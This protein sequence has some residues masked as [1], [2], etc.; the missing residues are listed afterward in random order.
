MG[1]WG[2]STRRQEQHEPEGRGSGCRSPRRLVSIDPHLEGVTPYSPMGRRAPV[3]EVVPALAGLAAALVLMPS[4]WPVMTA[5]FVGCSAV[6][7][8]FQYVS[9]RQRL[10]RQLTAA[11]PPPPDVVEV[12]RTRRRRT[13]VTRI[14]LAPAFLLGAAWLTSAAEHNPFA[15]GLVAAATLVGTG[16]A[17]DLVEFSTIRRWERRNGRV[18]KSL[19]LEGVFYVERGM[20]AG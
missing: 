3:A 5:L 18:L 11:P 12:R 20:H 2:A 1:A 10:R 15:W 16:F 4:L 17:A 9:W 13:T 14:L 19:L 7:A 8:L 6:A